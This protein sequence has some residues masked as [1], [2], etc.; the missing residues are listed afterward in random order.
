MLLHKTPWN[1]RGSYTYE[2][3]DDDDVRHEV[4]LRPGEDG[5]TAEDIKRLHAMDDSEVYFNLKSLNADACLSPEEKRALRAKK[6]AWAEG[7]I[8]GFQAQYGYEPH[9][10]DVADAVRKAFPKNWVDSIEYYTDHDNDEEVS[11]GD[12]ARIA[13]E[14]CKEEESAIL[15]RLAELLSALNDKEKVVYERVMLGRETQAS[16]G[17]DL[18]VSDR[19]VSQ[20]EKKIRAL[21]AEDKIL[22]NFFR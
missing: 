10:K 16:V 1:R 9:P 13:T 20:M 18:G 17:R 7:Y 19:R 12:S 4:V 8:A 22:L 11:L 2:Y 15:E 14:P 21:I 5:V 3:F 6:D